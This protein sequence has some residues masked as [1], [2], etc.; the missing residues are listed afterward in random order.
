MVVRTVC[1][2]FMHSYGPDIWC[3]GEFDFIIARIVQPLI[4]KKQPVRIRTVQCKELYLNGYNTENE[5]TYQKPWEDQIK[6]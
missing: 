3:F 6:V 2:N 4:F 1:Y 5:Y